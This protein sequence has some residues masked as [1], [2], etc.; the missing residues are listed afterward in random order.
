LTGE[1]QV[2]LDPLMG[3]ATTGIAAL[4]LKRK[5]IGIEIDE[6]RFKIADARIALAQGQTS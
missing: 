4:K 2:V 3:S 1:N 5:F 6:E